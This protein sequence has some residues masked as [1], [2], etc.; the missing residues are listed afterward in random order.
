MKTTELSPL[1]RSE[2]EFLQQTARQRVTTYDGNTWEYYDSGRLSDANAGQ[3]PLVCLP[4]TSGV[5]RCFHLQLQELGAKGYRVLAIQ[6]PVVWTHE[7]WIHSFDRFLNAMNLSEIHVYAVSLGAYLIQRYMSLYPQR[8]AS[9]VMTQGF[10]DTRVYGANA[11]CI[12]MLPYMPDFYVREYILERFPKPTPRLDAQNQAIEYMMDQLETLSQQEIASRLTLNCLSCDP[13][14]WKIFLPDEKITFI[15]SYEDTSL[16][17]SLKDQIGCRYPRAKQAMLKNGGDF[18][19]LSHHEEV[20]MHLQ[21]HL[22]ANGVFIAHRKWCGQASQLFERKCRK[23]SFFDLAS[24]GTGSDGERERLEVILK[25]IDGELSGEQV[26][27]IRYRVKVGDVVR[28]HGFVERLEGGTAILMHA[29]DM[30]VVRAWKE[31]NPGVTFLPLPTV[32]ATTN[33]RT[34]SEDNKQGEKVDTEAVDTTATVAKG[35]RVHCK[36]WINS[37]TCQHGDNCEFFHVSDADRKSERAKWLKERL[38]LKRV[39]AH[40]DDDPLDPHGKTGKQQR[41]Q[42]FVEWL[43]ETFGAE[44]LASGKGV[45]DVAGGRGSVSFE[46]W[47]KRRLPCTLIEP[48][49]MKLSKM[50]HKYLKKQKKERKQSGEAE[51]PLTESLVPQVTTLF[52]MDSF[53]EDTNNVQL[54]KQAS[55]LLGMHPDEATDSIFDVAIKFN[56]PFAV[57]PCCVFGQKFPDRRLADGSKV[58][59]YEN[60]VEYLAAKHP[61]IE[62]AFLPFDGKNLVL[63]RRPQAGEQQST[64]SS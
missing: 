41:A 8:V 9:L 37:K 11:P 29:R 54:V 44:F 46:L 23:C 12:K 31:E 53:L 21:V 61:D 32:V 63:F 1:R 2:Q 13:E 36:F 57:V 38:H 35:E 58:L 47:N 43:V 6:H 3:A 50:Q 15:D 51:L 19:F 27:A 7:E 60:L 18:P 30:T 20:T 25:I 39:R 5:A 56:K 40:I 55:L 42:V 16:P 26:D 48:R 17:N 45:V 64:S 28:V 59:S 62:K 24:V 52:N 4:G 33:K 14:S 22:R 49:P 34:Q 10:C